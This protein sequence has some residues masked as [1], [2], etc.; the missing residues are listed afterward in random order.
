MSDTADWIIRVRKATESR[1]RM[2]AHDGR[3]RL[4]VHALLFTEEGAKQTVAELTK[5]HA[6]YIFK[7]KRF[8]GA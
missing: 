1:S 8:G 5:K 3:T 6:S 4:R 7:A 2:L